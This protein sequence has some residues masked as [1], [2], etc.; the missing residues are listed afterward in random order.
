MEET[1]KEIEEKTNLDFSFSKP[2][3]YSPPKSPSKT[4]LLLSPPAK[5]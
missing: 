4:N 2:S 5:I 1:L 3:D